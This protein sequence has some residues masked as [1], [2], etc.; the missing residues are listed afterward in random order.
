MFFFNGRIRNSHIVPTVTHGR[1]NTNTVGYPGI[2]TGC[3]SII[4]GLILIIIGLISETEKTTF[5]GIGIISLTLGFL[6]TMCLFFYTKLN[7]YY[8]NWAYGT[9]VL[10]CHNP[11]LTAAVDVSISYFTHPSSLAQNVPNMIAVP[12]K[13]PANMVSNVEINKVIIAPSIGIGKTTTD[14]NNVT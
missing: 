11:E 5:F 4:I 1:P 6:I 10:P 9:H 2:I 13:K 7:I 14:T 12:S 3:L 8:R